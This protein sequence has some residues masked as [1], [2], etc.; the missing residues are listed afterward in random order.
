MDAW[1]FYFFPTEPALRAAEAGDVE[2]L[3][4]ARAVDG[5]EHPAE[6]RP[7]RRGKIGRWGEMAE[8]LG[9]GV[10][11][12]IYVQVEKAVRQ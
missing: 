2:R 11:L 3:W 1:R 10:E 5:E 9:E 8:K 6:R 7:G 4:R 12:G